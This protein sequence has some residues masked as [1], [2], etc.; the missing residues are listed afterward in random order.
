MFTGL[1]EATARVLE[2][3]SSGLSIERPQNFTDIK[4]GSSVAVAG[5]CLT[6]TRLDTERMSF[7]IVAETWERTSLRKLQEGDLV[8]LERALP[9]SSRIEGHFVQGH[10]DGVGE[11][12]E[13]DGTEGTKGAEDR[14]ITIAYPKA[15]RGLIVEKGSI[16]VDGVSLTVTTVD[17]DSFSAAL[18]PTTLTETTLGQLE[19]GAHVNLET[20]ILGKYAKNMV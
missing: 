14:R 13:T 18:I 1:I 5:A 16:A 7:D 11:V 17:A 15:L 12:R 8:N 19:E 3:T 6:V 10:V 2:R 4:P 9:V 20:D